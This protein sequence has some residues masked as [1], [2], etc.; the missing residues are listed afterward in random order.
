MNTESHE[1]EDYKNMMDEIASLE[2]MEHEAD[3]LE[4]IT[5]QELYQNLLLN[6]ELIICI[7]AEDEERVKT[8]LKNVK[9]KQAAKF[10]EE[11]LPVDS[12]TLA[13]TSSPSKVHQ[14]AINLH[15]TLTKKATVKVFSMNVPDKEM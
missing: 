4:D 13:F 12:S 15:I 14:G 7:A 3:S 6:E 10:K 1:D 5:Y 9:A 11:G 8:G 2:E